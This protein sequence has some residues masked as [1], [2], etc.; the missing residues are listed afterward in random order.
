MERPSEGSRQEDPISSAILVEAS[1]ERRGRIPRPFCLANCR[2][3]AYAGLF[4]TEFRAEDFAG[5]RSA[6]S[7]FAI[8]QGFLCLCF[9]AAVGSS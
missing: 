1:L 4:F 3:L 2:E 9:P 7:I 6:C 8:G 5:A